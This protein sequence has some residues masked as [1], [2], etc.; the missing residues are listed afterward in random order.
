MVIPK[1]QQNQ[2]A[3]TCSVE[4]DAWWMSF[5]NAEDILLSTGCRRKVF[6]I[7]K[8]LRDTHLDF[9]NTPI[10]NYVVKTLLL[11]ECEKHP[12]D[13]NWSDLE[14]GDRLIGW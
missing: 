14:M 4:G 3:N 1:Q 13:N 2:N 8:T 5:T 7:L 12:F 10:N 11:F 9:P 6:S